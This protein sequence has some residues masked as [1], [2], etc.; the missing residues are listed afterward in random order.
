MGEDWPLFL[1]LGGDLVVPKRD[2]IA[3]LSTNPGRKIK[4][5]KDLVSMWLER[6]AI[7][8]SQDAPV[9]SCVVTSKGLYLSPIS[10]TTLMKRS[11]QGSLF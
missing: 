8:V 11:E 1:H 7:V 10:P 2:I 9:K 3:I 6:G 4:A 5:A